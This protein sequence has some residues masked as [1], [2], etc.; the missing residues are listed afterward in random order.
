MRFL[1]T[2][3]FLVST[4]SVASGQ[5]VKRGISGNASANANGMNSRWHYWWHYLD[6][7]D[8]DYNVSERMPMLYAGY[9][10]AW[11]NN[12][13]DYIQDRGDQVNY[14]LGFNEPER[15][16]QG[17]TTVD[18]AVDAWQLIQNRF[19]GTGIQLVSPAVSDNT[20]GREWL[21]DFMQRVETNNMQVDAIAFHWYGNV[22]I[23]NPVGSANS[24][25]ARVDDY[26]N[27]Y[28]RPVWITEFAGVDWDGQ[29]TD[30]QMVA[31]NSAFLEHA[32]AGLEARDYVDRYAWFQFG[33]DRD[34]QYT[35]LTTTDTYGLRRPTPVGRA[36]TPEQVLSA[37]ET[38]DLG[39]QSQNGDYFY[40]HGGLLTNDGPAMDGHSVGGIYT[41]SND[42]GTLLASSIGGSSDWRVNAGAYVRVEE[43]ATLRKVGDNTVR[44]DGNRLYVDGQIRLMGGEGN[45]GT[46]AISETRETRGNGYFRMDFDSNLRLGTNS[47]TLGTHLPYDMQLRG[48]R[49]SVDGT[50]NTLSGDLTL[51]ESTT[52][53]VLGELDLQGN[54][55][56]S[57]GGQVRG[58]WKLG[59]GTLNLS[60]NNV[61]TGDIHANVGSLLVNGETLV[62]QVNVAS[63]AIL[64]GS[65]TIR[66]HVNALGTISPGN[67]TG[68]LTMDSLTL[69]DG[70]LATFEIGSLFDFDQLMIQTG[71]VIG[72]DVTLQLS[73]IDGFQPQVGDTFQIFTAGSVIGDFDNFDTPSLVNGVWDFRQLSSGLIQVTAVPEPGSFVVL[74]AMGLVW[75]W[76]RKRKASL[77]TPAADTRP[78]GNQS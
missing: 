77:R 74:A 25:L 23:N 13:I 32:I 73:L 35:R 36:Y 75:R 72:A 38:F 21:S 76:R 51:Y 4:L 16:D 31:F 54:F 12:A 55:L 8:S 68:L 53:D 26:H 37:G 20:H 1:L 59:S 50:D 6:P 11:L 67:S 29:Y 65:G 42:D 9:T 78:I 52:I 3:A 17:F 22:N 34:H 30:E 44:L 46:L 66:G 41:L 45:N 14:V 5:S 64:G 33:E 7:A 24:F 60:G 61:V 10:D 58:I 15:A 43:N 62:N 71:L 56:A 2:L 49:I 28:G 70:S 48:G 63:D 40:L 69:Q 57:P 47:P 19:Q 18:R 39:G 27:T